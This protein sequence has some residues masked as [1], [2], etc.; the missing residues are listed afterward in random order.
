MKSHYKGGIMS[1]NPPDLEPKRKQGVNWLLVEIVAAVV[2]AAFGVVYLN[3]TL[4]QKRRQDR[5]RELFGQEEIQKREQERRRQEYLKREQEV[6]DESQRQREKAVAEEEMW[7][8]DR[9]EKRRQ[10]EFHR[11]LNG[12]KTLPGYH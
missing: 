1:N 4:Q 6:M 8:L 2:V 5:A 12:G 3:T 11:S 9:M 10:D 7:R